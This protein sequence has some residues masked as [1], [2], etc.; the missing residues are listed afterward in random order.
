M[1]HHLFAVIIL[2]FL[3]LQIAEFLLGNLLV[4]MIVLIVPLTRCMVSA[5]S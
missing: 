3:T 1:W 5:Q 4:M 2:I